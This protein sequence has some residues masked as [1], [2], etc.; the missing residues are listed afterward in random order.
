MVENTQRIV[1]LVFAW[2]LFTVP[3]QARV[4]TVD[5]N[6]P[7][8]FNNIQDAINYSIAGDVIEVKP[9]VYGGPLYFN[10]RAVVLT[11]TDPN[12]PNV[13]DSTII[14][15]SVI[16]DFLEDS[17]SVLMGFTITG[18]NNGIKCL[19]TSPTIT[20]NAIS[21]FGAHAISGDFGASPTI[22]HNTITTDNRTGINNCDG[23]ISKNIIGGNQTGLSG[24]DGKIT[25]N[26]IQGNSNYGLLQCDGIIYNNTIADSNDS[27]L[28]EC[29]GDILGN[30]IK[31][32]GRLWPTNGGGLD[33]CDANIVG[34]TITF[35]I[36]R[37]HGAGLHEC[38]G[39]IEDNTIAYNHCSGTGSR[40]KGG[41]L[42]RCNG[43]ITDNIIVGNS[44][45]E[46]GGI[47][48]CDG[49]ITN[50]T[51]ADNN[52]VYSGG[53]LYDC[54]GNI[55]GNMITGNYA[56]GEGGGSGGGLTYCKG[57]IRNNVITD[58]STLGA[59]GG[60]AKCS[61]GSISNNLITANHAH[62]AGGG[63][64]GGTSSIINN[65]I[66]GNS[67][68]KGGAIHSCNILQNNIIAFNR[69]LDVGGVSGRSENNYNAFWANGINFGDGV[70]GRLGDISANPLFAVDGYWDV[71]DKWIEG[72]YH[73]KSEA[74]RWGP[75]SQTWVQDE[76]TSP[77]VDKGDPN[78]D[79][80]AEL[81]PHKRRINMGAY[82]GTSQGSMSPF[83]VGN[84]ADLNSDD[85][86][87]FRD[88]ADFATYW[89]IHG[90]FLPE[91]LN[92]DSLIDALD[93]AMFGGS[94]LWHE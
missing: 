74:G 42:Y 6:G 12:D 37:Q 72:D 43:G 22:T 71:N 8:D 1:I 76:A 36:A 81:W 60:L 29:D 87:D 3:C 89:Q 48:D 25:D 93:V 24:C 58:N 88:F 21:I 17:N 92:R 83:L 4:I 70:Y 85:K 20:K 86:V 41:G 67:A 16:F 5:A 9:G 32:N 49:S 57:D 77:C 13:V 61:H 28:F 84:I 73:L 79:W 40:G 62:W 19:S 54:D 35:N 7:A 11:S 80:A 69:A 46:G 78:S 66:V 30:V 31:A 55:T 50:N 10:A 64:S 33:R 94:W 18:T 14:T 45:D 53:G 63:I 52:A 90:F 59:G 56:A 65:T 38:N 27:G 15:G 39:N 34:N 91:D 2:L 44:S 75:G 82:G 23:I 26:T 47:Y 51:I 68:A